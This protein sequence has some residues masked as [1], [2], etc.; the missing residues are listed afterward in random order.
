MRSFE[1]TAEHLATME[2]L[3]IRMNPAQPDPEELNAVFRAAH[4]IKGGSGTFGFHEMT[5]LTHELET[6][7]D[8]AR[9]N[10]LQ[11]SDAMIDALLQAGDVLKAQ[12]DYFRGG[13]K[14]VNVDLEQVC[15][16]IRGFVDGAADISPQG[17]PA[18]R[19][20]AAERNVDVCFQLPAQ[21][22]TD[23]DL[24]GLLAELACLGTVER[25]MTGNRQLRNCARKP[26][27]GPLV[28]G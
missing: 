22:A 4:S 5:G 9:R 20:S 18:V 17:V 11:L 8:K 10:E 19:S 24:D 15:A 1:E 14:A 12:L 16:R 26:L 27:P 21:T 7:L 6:L 3:L 25:L 13:K 23:A 28:C 2:E